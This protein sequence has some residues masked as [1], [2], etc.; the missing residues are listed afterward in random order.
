MH[1]IIMVHQAFPNH[2]ILRMPLVQK[3]TIIRRFRNPSSPQSTTTQPQGV[4]SET[5][6]L[7][8]IGL[9]KRY[10]VPHTLLTCPPRAPGEACSVY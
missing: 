8:R 3:A 2:P 7:Q 4:P 6:I 9:R 5:D 10:L 1:D